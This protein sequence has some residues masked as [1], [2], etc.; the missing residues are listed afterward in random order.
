[1]LGTIVKEENVTQLKCPKC[2]NI[3][4]SS[5]GNLYRDTM[6]TCMD[7]NIPV[8]HPDHISKDMMINMIKGLQRDVENL[9]KDV[10]LLKGSTTS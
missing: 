8:F 10:E 9:R 2:N 5:S 6:A 1:M 3:V 4:I 7:C